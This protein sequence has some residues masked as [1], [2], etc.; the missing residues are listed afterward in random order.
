MKPAGPGIRTIILS[1]A[2]ELKLPAA[3]REV[4]LMMGV[5]L[6]SRPVQNGTKRL[7]AR[8]GKQLVCVRYRYDKHTEQRVKRVALIVER[9]E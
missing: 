7:L 2:N 5:G 8:Y 6:S 4:V 9:T 3:R 1:C